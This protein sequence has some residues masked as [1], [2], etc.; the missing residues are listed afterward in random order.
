M[1]SAFGCERKNAVLIHRHTRVFEHILCVL[2]GIQNLNQVAQ[3]PCLPIGLI[4]LF[5]CPVR[6]KAML[7]GAVHLSASDLHLNAHVFGEHDSGMNRFI[8]IA[9]GCR[10][11][12][13]ET[14]GHHLPPAMKHTQSTVTI[15]GRFCYNPKSINIGQLFK[16]HM[17][18]L[19]LFPDG[20]GMF[21]TPR[22]FDFQPSLLH[23]PSDGLVDLVNFDIG[24]I[25]NLL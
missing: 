24:L 23:F 13:F 20:I 21:L 1:Q 16:R 22:N 15:F 4:R 8:T 12:I 5:I 25:A 19:H 7:G 2:T 18:F 11:E 10:D 6:G 9:L 14:P 3:P 17:A